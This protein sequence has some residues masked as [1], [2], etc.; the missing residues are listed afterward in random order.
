MKRS[1]LIMAASLSLLA[2]PA[3]AQSNYMPPLQ[4]F[5]KNMSARQTIKA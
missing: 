3:L 2:A 5:C 1:L 4:I